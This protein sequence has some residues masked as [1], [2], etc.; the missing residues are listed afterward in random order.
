MTVRRYTG[1]MKLFRVILIA[2]A[3]ALPATSMA[4]WVWVDK[5][6]R[7]VLSDQPPPND[8]PAKSILR[9]PGGK[10]GQDFVTPPAAPEPA[11]PVL[12]SAKTGGKEKDLEDKK[13][14]GEAAEAE[15]LKA[16]SDERARARAE[17]CDRAKRS[18]ATY[19]SGARVARTNA[20]GEREFIDDATRAAETKRL[21]AIIAKDCSAAG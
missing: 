20:K 3:C 15:K 10:K 1:E 2:L 12:S 9:Q 18:K 16:Q 8:V 4:Q 7:K 19:D 13:K 17:N 5:D 11:K 21:E 6:G 14:A